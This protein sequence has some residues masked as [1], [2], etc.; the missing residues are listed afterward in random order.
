[1]ETY[2]VHVTRD[3]RWWM[4]AIPELDGLTQARRL[5]D[6]DAT[7]REYIAVTEDVAPSSFGMTMK[8][9]VGD[10]D[11]ASA[12]AELDALREQLAALEA[13]TAARTRN[14]AN[15]LAAEHVPL[16]DVGEALGVSY[17]R[18]HQLIESR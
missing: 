14:L 9:S 12:R 18:A 2:Q 17:Q 16:R 15:A 6:V 11:V 13:Q 3:G 1:M 8:V 4:I 10:L 7:A 5:A